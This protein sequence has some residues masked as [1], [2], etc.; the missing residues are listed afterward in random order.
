MIERNRLKGGLLYDN[1]SDQERGKE[2]YRMV[3][4]Q[5]EAVYQRVIVE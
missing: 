1:D 3:G 5:R 4:E 2:K